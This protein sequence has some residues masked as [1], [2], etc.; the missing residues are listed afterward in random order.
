ML[1]HYYVGKLEGDEIN[2][3]YQSVNNI[4]ADPLN[5]VYLFYLI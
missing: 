5:D 3:Y 1:S 4:R 2:V